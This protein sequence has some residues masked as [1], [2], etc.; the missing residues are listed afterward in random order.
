MTR[1]NLPYGYVPEGD[2][3]RG[4]S[5]GIETEHDTAPGPR[6]YCRECAIA[7]LNDPPPE[8]KVPCDFDP[9]E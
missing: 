8:P 9:P 6:F 3:Q 7:Y 1:G 4:A 5:V 2:C